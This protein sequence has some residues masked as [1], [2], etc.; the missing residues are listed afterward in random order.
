MNSTGGAIDFEAY[1]KTDAFKNGVRNMKQDVLG[2]THTVKT[3]SDK[4]NDTFKQMGKLAAGAF[5]FTELSSLPGQIARVRGEFQQLEIAFTTM[6]GSKSKADKLMAQTVDFAAKTPYGLKDTAAATKQLLAYGEGAETVTQTLTRLGDIASGIGA[7][8]GDIAY[9]YGTTMTQG[10]LYT[11]DLNQ[12]T[13]RGIPMIRELASIFGVAEKEV[14][15][16]VEAG[17]V[18][19]PE[20][21]K[22]IENLTKSGSMFGGLMEAQSKS[23]LGLQAQFGDAID[24]MLN[25]FGKSQEGFISEAIKGGI[26]LVENYQTIIDIMKVMVAAYGSYQAALMITAALQTRSILLT[27]VK[28]FFQLAGSIKSAADAQALFNLVTKANPIGLAIGLITALGTAY[29]VFGSK[30]SEAQQAQERMNEALAKSDLEM[31]KEISKIEILR[32]QITDEN[33]SRDEKTSKLKELIAL[34]PQILSGITLENSATGRATELINQYVRAKKEQ[35]RVSTIQSQIDGNL[36]K[37]NEIRSGK[38]DSEYDISTWTKAGLYAGAAESG[39][40]ANVGAKIAKEMASRK[41]QAIKE[42]Q[43]LNKGLMDQIGNGI[44]QR[45]AGRRKEQD[46]QKQDIKKTAEYYDEQIKAL[47]D[48]QTKE[49]TTRAESAAFDRQIAALEAKKRGITG[50]LSPEQKKAAKDAEK[51]AKSIKDES[52]KTFSEEIDEKKR[53]YEIYQRWVTNYGAESAK[54]Q[55]KDLL[56]SG[57]DYVAYLNKEIAR[58]ETMRDVGYSGS[59]SDADKTDLDKLISQR[60]E[61]TGGLSSIDQFKQSLAEAKEESATLTEYLGHLRTAQEKLKSQAPTKDVTDKIALASKD[62]IE[63]QKQRRKLLS[64]FLLNTEESEQK[65]MEIENHYAELRKILNERSGEEKTEAY[66][67]AMDLINRKESEE[68]EQRRI[69]IRNASNEYRTLLK[70]VEDAAN[71]TGLFSQINAQKDLVANLIAKEGFSDTAMQEQRKLIA[72]QSQMYREIA[73][74]VGDVGDALSEVDGDL[75]NIGKTLSGIASQANGL[76]TVWDKNS[77]STQKWGSAVQ[78]AGTL[79]NIIT[80]SAKQRKDA[81]AEYYNSVIGQQ[82]QYNLLL[83]EQIGLRSKANSSVFHTDFAG[84]LADGYSKSEDAMQNYLKSLEEVEKGQA[85]TGKKAAVSWQAIGAG[86]VSGATAGGIAGAGVFSIPGAI[87]GGIGGAL[88]GLIGGLKKKDTFA[89]ILEAYPGL[90]DESKEGIDQ[91][92]VALAQTLISNNLIDEA[93]KRNLQSTVDW[94]EA[95]REGQEQIKG[96]ISS[97][98]GS[99]GE[100]IRSELETAF[101]EGTSYAEAFGR[102]TSKILEKLLDQMIFSKVMG[103]ALKN[104]EKEMEASSDLAKGG[105]GNWIDDFGRFLSTGAELGKIYEQAKLDAQKEAGKYGMNLW[106]DKDAANRSQGMSGVVKSLTEETGSL[107]LGQFNALRISN[108]DVASSIRQMLLYQANISKNSD[109]QKHLV[110]IDEKLTILSEISKNTVRGWG[111]P[112]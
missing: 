44:E 56:T 57:D 101:L 81:E 45:R 91:F 107:M 111:E 30:V 50:G 39:E 68:M 106:D 105:D 28:A 88:V 63:V 74:V 32:K 76:I 102:S 61:A 59:L 95:Y 70:A 97:L 25:D 17:K 90:I 6:L 46:D 1:I 103:P 35:I 69:N 86:A 78:A 21:Q 10:R 52:V 60:T 23:I 47:K 54:Q 87:I 93:T 41:E 72:M 33:R 83:N 82:S 18:G 79:L 92:N 84:T 43:D 80:S 99:L 75:G 89:P 62:E 36:E 15:G 14:K 58:I 85:K 11:Q 112:G 22:V 37:V 13:G 27:E 16:L 26:S 109:Y 104:L 53:M 94:V 77:T 19:F 3:E 29:F 67:K 7:P 110:S 9:L 12:F 48:K 73:G 2:L 40:T 5:A 34:N 108:A 42:I 64:D 24:M 31:S 96:V 66:Q 51:A 20:V 65:R 4:M 71:S 49:A 8:L 38:L 98:A 100:G 55:F